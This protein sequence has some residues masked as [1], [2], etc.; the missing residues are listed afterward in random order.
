LSKFT[1]FF[2][3]RSAE[4]GEAEVQICL[5]VVDRRGHVVQPEDRVD[6]GSPQP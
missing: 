4:R 6:H 1:V 3:R 5:S 2:T